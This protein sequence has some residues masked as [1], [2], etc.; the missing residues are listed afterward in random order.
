MLLN[1]FMIYWAL[2]IVA[3]FYQIATTPEAMNEIGARTYIEI[4]V[5][6]LI[7]II[8]CPF[9]MIYTCYYYLRYGDASK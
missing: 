2:S 7:V 4:S 1:A 9:I 5:F 6:V 3:I 8:I